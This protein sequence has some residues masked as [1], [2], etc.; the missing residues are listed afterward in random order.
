MTGDELKDIR[1]R[2]GLSRSALAA[3]AE[4]NHDSVRYWERKAKVDLRG[5]VPD[6]IFQALGRVT[7]FIATPIRLGSTLGYFPHDTRARGG[8]L[9]ANG[10]WEDGKPCGALTRK[11]TACRAKAING[12]GRCKFHGGMSTGPKTPEGR[13]RIAEAQRRRWSLQRG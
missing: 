11:G 3:L 13:E 12:K 6:R 4:L 1:L 7:W 2:A 8:V 5:W 9:V 10:K